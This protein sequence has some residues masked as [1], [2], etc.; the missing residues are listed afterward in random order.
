[1]TTNK[2]DRAERARRTAKKHRPWM[3]STGPRTPAGKARVRCN[4]F[5]FG[6]RTTD[7]A[8]CTNCSVAK[9][10]LVRR[11]LRLD[12]LR[13]RPWVDPTPAIRQLHRW[14]V[15]VHELDPADEWATSLMDRT[16]AQ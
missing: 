6:E 10:Q 11:M 8:T 7:P 5:K 13:F 1:M 16:R 14:A 2:L 3:H 15:R 9:L 12:R 4:A